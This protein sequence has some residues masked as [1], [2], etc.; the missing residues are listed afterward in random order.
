MAGS[1][2][3]KQA[4][5][6]GSSSSDAVPELMIHQAE[7]AAQSEQR[8]LTATE[9]RHIGH[10]VPIVAEPTFGTQDVEHDIPPPAYGEHYGEM[11]NDQDGFGS[12]AKVGDDGR[13]NIRIKQTSRKFSSLMVPALRQQQSKLEKE[14]APP[15][16]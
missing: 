3:G 9:R 11:R 13:V 8:G 5:K 2:D 10:D 6:A 4:A 15:P 14:H 12:Q 7:A 1:K 16:A